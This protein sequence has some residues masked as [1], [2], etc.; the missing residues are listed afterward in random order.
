MHSFAYPLFYCLLDLS[1]V[2]TLFS[3]DNEERGV[4]WP[5][6]IFMNFRDVD[7]LK[8]GE[9]LKKCSDDNVDT[10]EIDNDKNSLS[11]RVGRLVSERTGGK[12]NPS[13]GEKKE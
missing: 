1:E 9:G 12:C 3:N 6:S 5:L 13:S 7:H 8:N 4:L 2:D 11:N 10:N